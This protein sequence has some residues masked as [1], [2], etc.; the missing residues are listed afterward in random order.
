[1]KGE[2]KALETFHTNSYEDQKECTSENA[3]TLEKSESLGFPLF[4]II[5]NG[6]EKI[7][8][9]NKISTY[10]TFT[11]IGEKGKNAPALAIGANVK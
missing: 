1:M 5:K 2:I 9:R 8:N 10:N 3:F 4:T 11:I 7:I 6:K